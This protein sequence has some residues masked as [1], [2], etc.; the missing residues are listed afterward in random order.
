MASDDLT[1]RTE[2]TIDAST[3][4]LGCVMAQYNPK[5]V[6]KKKIVSLAERKALLKN[7]KKSARLGLCMRKASFIGCELVIDLFN[8]RYFETN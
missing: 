1:W 8:R 7:C 3:A 6:N 2:I 5:K 4:G